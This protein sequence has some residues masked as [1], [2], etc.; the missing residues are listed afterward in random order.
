MTN[1]KTQMSNPPASPERE[2]WRAGQAQNQNDRG[3][4]N[5]GIQAFGFQLT[6][7]FWHLGFLME[8]S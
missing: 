8:Q 1:D 2:G 6:F 5:F 4:I 3:E 7:G